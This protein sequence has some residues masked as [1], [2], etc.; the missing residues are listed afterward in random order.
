MEAIEVEQAEAFLLVAA[1]LVEAIIGGA[2]VLIDFADL[3]D[4]ACCSGEG[5]EH[6]ELRFR[7]EQVLLLVLAMN[8]GES[9]SEIA[10]DGQGDH[11]A[12]DVGA[13]FAAFEDFALDDYFSIEFAVLEVAILECNRCVG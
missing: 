7:G 9:G 4:F 11:A 8:V 1:Q 10:Q 12:V 13:G 6:F 3:L 2:P 5:I